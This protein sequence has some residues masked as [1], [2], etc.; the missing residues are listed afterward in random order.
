M[1]HISKYTCY[2]NTTWW[3]SI[4]KRR[5]HINKSSFWIYAYAYSEV[6]RATVQY[7]LSNTVD[8]CGH[9]VTAREDPDPL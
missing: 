1:M 5:P 7:C 4:I 8:T 9:S 2:I 3:Y 6:A